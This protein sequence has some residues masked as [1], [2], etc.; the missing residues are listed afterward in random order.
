MLDSEET[1][2]CQ[3]SFG[4]RHRK[5][6][7]KCGGL[8]SEGLEEWRVEDWRVGGFESGGLEKEREREISGF[9][10]L[11]FICFASCPSYTHAAPA[12]SSGL[13]I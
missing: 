8:E 5:G 7:W 3:C 2:M 9:C 4:I 12:Y 1:G 10:F 13:S 11:C 6:K